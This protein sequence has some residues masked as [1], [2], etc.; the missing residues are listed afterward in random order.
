MLYICIPTHDEAPTIGVL[1]WRIRKVFQEYARE[2]EILVYDDA[3]TDTTREILEP[4]LKA[5]PLTVL[6]TASRVGYGRASEA[7]LKEVARRTKYP[8]RD[9]VIMMQADFTD[10]PEH[11]PDLV[12]RF[13]GGADVVVGE[14]ALPADAPEG[15]KQLHKY[16]SWI[17]KFWLLR[18]AVTV[19]GANDPWSSFWL[20]RIT[21]VR[22]LLRAAERGT[23]RGTE[24]AAT[25][26]DSTW[27]ANLDVLRAAVP[28]ARRIES[29]PVTPRF[30]VRPR[31]SRREARAEAWGLAK[32]AW[33]ARGQPLA[34]PLPAAKD[35][36]PS[37]AQTPAP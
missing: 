17:P 3:S 30:D 27:Q 9:A 29:V 32:A 14:R 7:L 13:E 4:Y 25:T 1:L 11:I 37:A 20:M 2:Y 19:P 23:E 18:S 6:G 22:D 8:R 12:K 36:T 28:H 21:V 10:R 35:S 16:V 15:V 5:L 34:T 31:P 26:A 24:R 33:A